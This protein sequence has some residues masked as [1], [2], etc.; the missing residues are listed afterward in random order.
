MVFMASASWVPSDTTHMGHS[1]LTDYTL[2]IFQTFSG[3]YANLT[4]KL[5][6]LQTL[7]KKGV[8]KLWD[9]SKITDLW[10]L[11]NLC[12]AFIDGGMIY[13]VDA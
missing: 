9:S 3:K 4:E 7:C 11:N 13:W 8:T 2:E 6:F 5:C 10:K 12:H 1:R